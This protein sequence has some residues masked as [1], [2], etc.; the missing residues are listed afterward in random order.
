MSKFMFI[1]ATEAAD[2]VELHKEK[3]AETVENVLPSCMERIDGVIRRSANRGINSFYIEVDAMMHEYGF[4]ED[5]LKE[6]TQAMLDELRNFG[7]RTVHEKPESYGIYIQW[8]P[9]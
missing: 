4:D 9:D 1:N 8:Y 6:L 7:Y 3:V 2:L 5:V